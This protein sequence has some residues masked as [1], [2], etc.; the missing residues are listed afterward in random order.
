MQRESQAPLGLE[1]F[2]TDNGSPLMLQCDNSRVMTSKIMK[3][4]WERKWR[5]KLFQSQSIKIK[6]EQNEW[7][8]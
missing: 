3:K 4:I 2:L 6:I 8:K 7:F 5:N 1:D